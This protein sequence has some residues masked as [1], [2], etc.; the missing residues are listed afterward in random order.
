LKEEI[1]SLEAECTELG[2]SG[3]DSDDGGDAEEED[4][5]VVFVLDIR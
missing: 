4:D 1:E 5:R 3:S 2:E